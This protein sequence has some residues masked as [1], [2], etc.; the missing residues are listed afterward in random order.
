MQKCKHRQRRNQK[1][2]MEELFS[3]MLVIK[4]R[5]LYRNFRN[6]ID[7]HIVIYLTK[8]GLLIFTLFVFLT[9]VV[10]YE[11]NIILCK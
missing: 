1:F 10:I 11:T 7:E 9:L 3:Y 2:L 6:H 5:Q 4:C 8:L